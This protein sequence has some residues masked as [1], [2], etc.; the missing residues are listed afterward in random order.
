MTPSIPPVYKRAWAQYLLLALV[1][2]VLPAIIGHPFVS[3]DN[4]IQFNPLRI[5][6]GKIESRGNLP[7][8][9]QY[10][11]SGTPLLAG[12]NAGVFF[13]TSWL[14]IFLPA[15]LSWGISQ[16]LPYFLAAF[17]FYLLMRENHIS[18]LTSRLTGLV[19]AY[20]GVMIAQGVHL[21]M[22]IGVS[23]APWLLLF[24]GRIIE[25]NPSKRLENSLLLAASFSLII[26]AGAPEAML[27][28]MIMVS[29]FSLVKQVAKKG[30]W[31]I[32]FCWFA[33][34]G[35]IALG[36]SAAQWVPGLAYQKISQRSNPSLSFVSFGAFSPRYFFTLFVPYL[37]GGP[38]AFNLPGY[39]GPFNWEEVVIYPTIG[40]IIALINTTWNALKGKMDNRLTPYAVIGISGVLLALGSYTPLESLLHAVPLYGQQ[41][42]SG[43][44]MLSFDVAI[45]AVFAFWLDHIFSISAV[46]K[47][48]AFIF[49][50]TPALMI[51]TLYVGLIYR[52]GYMI[53]IFQATPKPLYLTKALE[54][55]VFGIQFF[56]ALAAGIVFYLAS[57][58]RSEKVKS[59]VIAVILV[60]LISF[61]IFGTLGTPSYSSQFSGTSQQMKYIH[62]LL[63]ND[64]RF[65]IY[66]PNLYDYFYLN[67][68][69]EPDINVEAANHSIGGYSSLSLKSYE[70]ATGTHAQDS[71]NPNLLSGNL[72]D[73]LG[74]KA[75]FTSWRYLVSR[76]GSPT[77]VPLPISPSNSSG[78]AISPD[79][80]TDINSSISSKATDTY[81]YFGREFRVSGIDINLANKFTQQSIS[82]VGLITPAGSVTWLQP[83]TSST[84]PTGALHYGTSSTS[85]VIATGVVVNQRLPKSLHDTNHSL[86]VG[87]GIAASSGYFALHGPLSTYLTYPHYK[88]LRQLGD[89][90]VFINTRAQKQ[91]TAPSG[92]TRIISQHV[93]T[94]GSL[95]LKI[96]SSAS[97]YINWAEAYAPGWKATYSQKGNTH[98]F[99]KLVGQDGPT[100]RIYVPTGNWTINVSY[101]PSSPYTGIKVSIFFLAIFFILV[102]WASVRTSRNRRS[103]NDA[104]SADI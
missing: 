86:L 39:F 8:W 16:G 85:P 64:S 103:S 40:P 73:T 74:A 70:N 94:N 22:I 87:I 25:G 12:F 93:H 99:V 100:Q 57:L 95:D 24:A 9:N 18:E 23:L 84:S 62:T 2:F 30:E 45:F 78:A 75:I 97:S 65:A 79:P 37:F 38:G 14:Y 66:D 77:L 80:F 17:G 83:K 71:I 54:F 53:K 76:Y 10:I 19:F 50:F 26:L 43:R 61:N 88:Y 11:W 52:G 92:K 33:L 89:V 4:L 58:N 82:Q 44:N 42:L 21:D 32:K 47:L 6:A 104:S 67:K 48:R 51:A 36:L 81:G 68:L 90:S 96:S 13:P 28:E 7:L 31:R 59:L 63:G 5:L 60:D 101:H 1:V 41:R 34:A 46:K 102:I 27:D 69:G 15:T 55:E 72:I 91:L 35:I 3:G 49:A 56:V 29:I 20:S 98:S